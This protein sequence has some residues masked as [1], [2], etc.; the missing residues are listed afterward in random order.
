M[1]TLSVFRSTRACCRLLTGAVRGTLA[2]LA[3]TALMSCVL[4]PSGPSKTFVW[5]DAAALFSAGFG[6]IKLYYVKEPNIPRMVLLGLNGLSD[7]DPGFRAERDGDQIR[8]FYRDKPAAT[9]KAPADADVVR[10]SYLTATALETARIQSADIAEAELERAYQTIFDS[11]L[12]ELDRFSRYQSA[13]VAQSSR[14][15][16]QGYSGIGISLGRS[17]EFVMALEVFEDTP[18][19]EAGV[20]SGDIIHTVDGTNIHAWPL[21]KVAPILRGRSGSWVDLGLIR[22]GKSLSVTLERRDVIEQTVFATII[23]ATSVIR[24]TGFN[25]QTSS[26]M[27]ERLDAVKAALGLA[28]KG[29]VLD[30]RGNRGGMLDEAVNL[31]DL[32][33]HDGTILTTVGRHDDARQIF[34]AEPD[35]NAEWLRLVVLIDSGSASASEVVAAALQDSGR[36][37][38]IDARS[39][40]KGSVQRVRDLPNNGALNLTWASMRA[41][42]GY[43][44]ARFGVFPTICTGGGLASPQSVLDQIRRGEILDAN[45]GP[46]RRVAETLDPVSQSKLLQ[47]CAD[48]QKGKVGTDFDL[49]LALG[50]LSEPVLFKRI[51]DQALLAARGKGKE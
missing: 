17:D 36:G 18:A 49:D 45:L 50:L 26:R 35:D 5:D 37:L 42:S 48:R 14:S 43:T 41:P 21:A 34:S 7:L 1:H 27:G 13:K 8:L 6:T 2:A 20:R 38:V 25:E 10:W 51:I 3:A 15:H 33:I 12:A 32:F 9:F 46:L 40:G 19:A 23:N 22:E 16:R 29:V 47:R 44:L 11:A 30:L 31:A 24:V 39:Y 28:L 4:P